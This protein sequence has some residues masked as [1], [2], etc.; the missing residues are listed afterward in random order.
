MGRK[1]DTVRVGK[2]GPDPCSRKTKDNKKIIQQIKLSKRGYDTK[3]LA[4]QSSF[5]SRYSIFFRIRDAS[6]QKNKKC[7]AFL[8]GI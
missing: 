6:I 8:Q 1:H 4:T 3:N 7:A 5:L 2:A